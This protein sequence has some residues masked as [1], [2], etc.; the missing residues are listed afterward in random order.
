MYFEDYEVGMVFD[1]IEPISFREEEL[2]EAG[3]KFDPRLI[4]IDKKAAEKSH[5]GQIIGP[6]S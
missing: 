1:Q 4:H 5:F 6:G 2:I 3:K